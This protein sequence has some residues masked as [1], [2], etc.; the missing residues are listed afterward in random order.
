MSDF[1]ASFSLRE[2]MRNSR[3]SS[4]WNRL[5]LK[6]RLDFKFDLKFLNSNEINKN[7]DTTCNFQDS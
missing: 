2:F 7:D 6:N 3:V 1:L 4:S 5:D